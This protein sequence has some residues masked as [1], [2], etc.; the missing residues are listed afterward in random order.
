MGAGRLKGG[1]LPSPSS[2]PSGSSPSISSRFWKAA[3]L[4]PP[5][6][7][8]FSKQRPRRSLQGERQ[9]QIPAKDTLCLETVS[10][11]LITL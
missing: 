6:L 7:G 8:T 3:A 1:E 10:F 9:C 4:R 5:T 11:P 2:L